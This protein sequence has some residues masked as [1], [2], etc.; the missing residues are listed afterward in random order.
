VYAGSLVDGV[1]DVQVIEGGGGRNSDSWYI[2]GDL[3]MPSTEFTDRVRYRQRTDETL[4]RGDRVIITVRTPFILDRCCRPVDGAHVGGRVPL[5]P[6]ATQ[7]QKAAPPDFCQTPPS[8]IGPWTSGTGTGAGNFESWFCVE[9]I[10][11]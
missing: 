6:E 10:K 2:A 9:E 7:T 11:K 5:L 3:V 1:I 8:G 4:Q